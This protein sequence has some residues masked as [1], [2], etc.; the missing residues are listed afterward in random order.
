MSSRGRKQQQRWTDEERVRDGD[1]EMRDDEDD[2]EAAVSGPV[3]NGEVPEPLPSTSNGLP[4]H[5]EPPPQARMTPSS[6]E[7]EEDDDDDDDEVLPP[8]P[9]SSELLAALLTATDRQL[10]IAEHDVELAR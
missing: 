5:H 4:G 3:P 2:V 1:V 7:E 10:E 6:S 8:L 9:S